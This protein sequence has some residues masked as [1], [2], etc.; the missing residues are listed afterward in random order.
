MIQPKKRWT[1]CEPSAIP[2]GV[3]V[4]TKTEE[5]I[6]EEYWEYWKGKMIAAGKESM[7]SEE[8]CIE[9]WV[10]CHWA[11]PTDVD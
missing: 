3:S 5:Q 8:N 2:G 1:Y 6:L 11:M 10:V 7:I 9:D 4:V